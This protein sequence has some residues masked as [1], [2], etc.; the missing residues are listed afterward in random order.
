LQLPPIRKGKNAKS[1]RNEDKNN[2]KDKED[3]ATNKKKMKIKSYDYD[4]W[5]KFDVVSFESTFSFCL[6]YRC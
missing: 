6:S 4:A 1:D 5:S 3:N 2:N